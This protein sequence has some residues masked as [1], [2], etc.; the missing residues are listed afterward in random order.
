MVQVCDLNKLLEESN[1]AR[2]DHKTRIQSLEISI[3]S[4]RSE[5]DLKQREVEAVERENQV[6]VALQ[7]GFDSFDDNAMILLFVLVTTN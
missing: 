7:C 6:S 4:M 1:E 5:R 3:C 2:H